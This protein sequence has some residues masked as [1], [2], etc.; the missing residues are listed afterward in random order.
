MMCERCGKDIVKYDACNY[1]GRKIGFE[2]IKSQKKVSATERAY[3]CKDC[4]SNTRRR[5]KYKSF[6]ILK[7]PSSV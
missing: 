6:V 3:I 7:A 5:N 1:C 2:C 4:W